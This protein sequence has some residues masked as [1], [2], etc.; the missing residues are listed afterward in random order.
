MHRAI[1]SV[2]MLPSMLVTIILS[3]A[4]MVWHNFLVNAVE[5]DDDFYI[6]KGTKA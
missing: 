1:M 3:S 6:L 5:V 2:K 4:L